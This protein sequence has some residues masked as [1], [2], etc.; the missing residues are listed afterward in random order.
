VSDLLGFSFD[1]LAPSLAAITALALVGLV[2]L[3]VRRPHLAR[4]GLR[5]MP[6]RRLRT[7]LIVFGL[8]LATTFVAAAFA[9]DD[10]ITLAVKTI[11]IFNLG[12]VDEQVVGGDGPLR[13]Y[14]SD[15]GLAV[16]Q[17]LHGDREVA[18]VA[19]ALVVPNLLV[20]DQTAREVRGGVSGL[21]MQTD[22]AGP[23]GDLRTLAGA[24]APVD[25]LGPRDA[26]LSRTTASFLNAR[27]G[28][29]LQ[30]YSNLWPGQ[31]YT[32][33]VRAIVTGGPLGDF[34][35][36]VIPLATLQT[37]VGAPDS[38][39]QIYVANAGDGL[40]GVSYSND[41]ARLIDLT[42][43]DGIHAI[44]A[45]LNGVNFALSAQQI[46]GRILALFTLFALAIGLLLIF[47]I[48]V[49]LAAERRAELGMARALGMRRSHV[50]GMLLFEGSAYDSLAALVG[51]LAGLGLGIGI[52]AIIG[53]TVTQLGF[54]LQIAI[55]PASVI[56][57]FCLG[58]LF[59]LAT[60]LL[61]AWTV[62]QMT[63]AAAM[64]DLP[65]P[66]PPRPG[67]LA[68]LRG[69]LD[70]SPQPPPRVGEGRGER[71]VRARRRPYAVG[72]ASDGRHMGWRARVGAGGA[73]LRWALTRGLVPLALG[74]WLVQRGV[75]SGDAL[76]FSLGVS[77]VLAGLVLALRGAAL[78]AVAGFARRQHPE[79]ALGTIA[80]ATRVA[81]RIT[82]IL[83]GGGLALYWSLPF[84]SLA[85]LGLARFT[86]GIQIFFIAGVMMV[87]GAVW[88]IAPN[89][90]LVLAPLRAVL[91][92]LGRLRH[93]TRIALIY[94]AQQR[95]RTGIGL[96]LFSLVCFTMVVMACI[97][98]STTQ[99]YD[100]LPQQAAGFDFAGQ[101]LFSPVGGVG[102]VQ[103]ALRRA[104]AD[105]AGVSSVSLATPL[106]LA[107]LQPGN[108]RARW[109]FYP[110]S[111]VQGAFLN[112][113]GLPLVARA[114]GLASDAAVWDA[115]RTH[116]G[117]VVVDA[118]ALT[119]QDAALL[120][121][122]RPPDVSF[123]QFGGAPIGAGLP[124]LAPTEALTGPTVTTGAQ[125]QTLTE[126]GAFLTDNPYAI[127][128][129][130]LRLRGIATG[131]H[132]I[133]PTP[134]WVTDLRGGAAVKLTI[135]GVVDNS[136]GRRYGLFGSSATFAPVEQGLPPFGNEYYY[137]QVRPGVDPATA[138][139]ATG[140]ALIDHGFETTVLQ[141]VLLDVT[142]PR[143][144]ISRVLVGL[145]GLTLLVGMAA[146]AVSGSRA[147]VERRQQIGM[148]RALGFRRA[149]V[150]LIFLLE[151]LLVGVLGMVLGV[152]LG[153]ILCRN[154]FAVDFFASIQSGLVFVVPWGELAAICAAAVGAAL[155][156]A[157]LPA[158]QAGRVAPADALRYE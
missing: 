112:G 125:S 78:A 109:G 133:A 104:G 18:G 89:L 66:P 101:P 37:I 16:R 97:A 93:A 9:V 103:A 99:S 59:T 46:F 92:R 153:L 91:G 74:W 10:T 80:L 40:S 155:L 4:I 87:F 43:P 88:A 2:V 96:A 107:I 90:D 79:T 136:A 148:L 5:N 36:F 54:P 24:T 129:Y 139:L 83:A 26:Y 141:N 25:A 127:H 158:W 68:L 142:G 149:H 85:G 134:I 132:A 69:A 27:A 144:F 156:A 76:V 140:S 73:L 7:G 123:Q 135:V 61:A 117:D 137:F 67:V 52:I 75:A 28:D 33:H 122:Q 57:S 106:P 13:L 71:S 126:I 77:L 95:F 147:V 23:L 72:G 22:S 41:I 157:L 82:A 51:L 105:Q 19:P 100:N 32:F 119:G 114:P 145:V 146:L 60:M 151:A 17:V 65:E 56:V 70:L 3:A 29:T 84:D 58:F 120:G 111:Q 30:L 62:S 110:V 102:A 12:R 38:I 55:E 86:G 152:V 128:D 50:V 44:T 39:N 94:P 98:A 21:G 130:L 47:L 11:A 20:A 118:G 1:T 48:F 14:S 124:G 150:Q 64:R 81:D 108:P 34:P 42:T 154:V 35:S 113:A 6:R 15:V 45:K 121:T 115:V 138:A 49:L 8:M 116:P 53:P 131:P 143:V 31:R 63:I